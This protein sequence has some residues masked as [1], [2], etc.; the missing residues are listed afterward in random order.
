MIDH[1]GILASVYDRAIPFTRVEFMPTGRHT[2]KNS[3]MLDSDI[4]VP[5]LA[6]PDD[7]TFMVDYIIKPS[8]EN[9]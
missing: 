8:I 6:N 9:K 1:F 4:Q 5:E 7:N 3:I 2:G